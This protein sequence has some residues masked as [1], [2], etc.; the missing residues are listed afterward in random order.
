MPEKLVDPYR[1]HSPASKVHAGRFVVWLK[2]IL[3]A[4]VVLNAMILVAILATR[5][6][7]RE[8]LETRDIDLPTMTTVAFS[9]VLPSLVVCLLL[10]TIALHSSLKSER[11]MDISDGILIVL[12]GGIVGVYVMGMLVPYFSGPVPLTE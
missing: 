6:P 5:G 2:S 1:G 9:T 11:S 7:L 4:P 12:L 10:A 3:V 8:R